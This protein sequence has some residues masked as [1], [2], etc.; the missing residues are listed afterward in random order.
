MAE[1]DIMIL[2]DTNVIIESNCS[3][4]RFN[5]SRFKVRER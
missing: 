2:C 5:G 1:R 4:S 3:G